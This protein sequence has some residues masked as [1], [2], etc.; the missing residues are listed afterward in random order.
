M[1]AFF[2]T[3]Q[4]FTTL[5]LIPYIF[6][7]RIITLLRPEAYV[8]KETDTWLSKYVFGELIT[9]PRFQSFLACIFIFLLANF[10]NRLVI[11]NRLSKL[12]TQIPG[13]VFILLTSLYKSTLNLSPA[14]I[15][16]FFVLLSL[17]HLFRI[18]KTRD[19]EVKIFNA[20]FYI[21]LALLFYPG[22]IILW[23]FGIIG[24]LNLRSFKV[25]EL[26]IFLS[27][28][29]VPVFLLW[30]IFYWNDKGSEIYELIQFDKG[31]FSVLLH[32]TTEVLIWLI[33][34]GIIVGF[35][36]VRYNNY[37]MKNAIQ[38]QKKIDIV[39]WFMLFTLIML[40]FIEGINEEHLIFTA[41]PFSVFLGL[42][43]E[44]M[45]NHLIAEL[46]HIVLVLSILV[47]HFQIYY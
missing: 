32:F 46:L 45:K 34:T 29:I 35:S 20:G 22:V 5:L 31:I 1:L 28:I 24:L 44:R 27:G 25:S 11:Q 17:L 47:I 8:P 2:R 41:I 40:F 33:F 16:S 4:F 13:I 37:T 14:M 7:I 43:Y 15:A 38:V 3:N 30:T 21:G 19:A 9:G 23:I 36:I 10:V 26:F 18:Y 6:L 42:S 12:L 39:Y